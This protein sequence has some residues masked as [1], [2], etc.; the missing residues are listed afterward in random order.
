MSRRILIVRRDNIGDL[1]LTTPLFAA[2]RARMPDATLDVLTNS[3]AAP[4][5]AG[6]PHLD[7]V[8]VYTKAHHRDDDESWLGVY[9]RRART[10]LALRRRRYDTIL[11]AKLPAERRPLQFARMIGADEIVGLVKP[12][13][14]PLSGLTRGYVWDAAR[15]PH[16]VQ[17]L[18]QLGEHFGIAA[19]G[20]PTLVRPD[21]R[22]QA[23]AR[24]LLAPLAARG[25]PLVALNLSARK[26]KQRWPVARFVALARALHARDGCAFVL[27]WSPGAPDNP[28]H[29][30]DDDKAAEAG[31]G[32]AG[33]PFVAVRTEALPEL[34]GALSLVD[35]MI[36]ADG[37]AMHLGAAVGL[38]IV[39][40]FGN[41]DPAMWHPWHVPHEVLQHPERDVN[42]IAVDE[43][44]AAWDRLA[45]EGG[46]RTRKGGKL[47]AEATV[48]ADRAR[49]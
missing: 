22:A 35:A 2:L 4:I 5:L 37:G 17:A 31:Q 10:V 29:P 48:A 33:V 1:A 23:E 12:G 43:V 34:V 49:G 14:P 36:T 45:A 3:Y 19:P 9:A 47:A 16:T 7:A 38:P 40:L 41:S 15:C 32:L 27:V 24:A 25:G 20:G 39:A 30:G 26:V 42:L 18:M 8:H 11:L 21:A 13:G 46:L 6:N 28:R 44:L